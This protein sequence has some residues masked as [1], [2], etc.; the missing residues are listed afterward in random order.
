MIKIKNILAI[1]AYAVLTFFA[2][3]AYGAYFI[4][5][6]KN[7][8]EIK[9]DK[10][11]EDGDA[12]RFYTRDG[13]V[14]IP[15]D[16]IKQIVPGTG[17]F[18]LQSSTEVLE[19]LDTT[20][21]QQP[22]K[23]VLATQTEENKKTELVNDIKDR[24]TITETNLE[25]LA[26]NKN[27]YMSQNEQFLQQKQKSEERLATLKNDPFVSP[28]DLKESIEF[29][30]SRL[31]DIQ[32]KIKDMETKIQNNDKMIET[33]QRMKARLEGELATANQ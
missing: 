26:K 3:N 13:V 2:F 1:A 11:W 27:V 14:G 4:I 15:Q 19:S 21:E 29:E 20:S 30:E 32:D 33:Q 7:G 23:G 10:Y 8:N 22:A 24:I 17:T 28:K 31:K 9:S 5:Q 12:I 16:I 6:L 25:N 18:E